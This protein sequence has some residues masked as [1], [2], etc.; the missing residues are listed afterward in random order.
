MTHPTV[1]PPLIDVLV[2]FR[3]HPIAVTADMSKM[4]RAVKLDTLDKD[5]HRFVWHTNLERPI[6]DYCMTRV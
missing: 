6:V 2:R 4:Y 3:K 1:H 5:L